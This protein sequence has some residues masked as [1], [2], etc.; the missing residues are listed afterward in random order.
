MPEGTVIKT[1]TQSHKRAK[2]GKFTKTPYQTSTENNVSEGPEPGKHR[3]SCDNDLNKP[4]LEKAHDKV[5][6]MASQL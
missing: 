6:L 3:R 5:A 4:A 2:A 1:C